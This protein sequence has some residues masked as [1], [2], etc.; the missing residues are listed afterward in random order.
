MSAEDYRREDQ[1]VVQAS[2]FFSQLTYI[3]RGSK[4]DT[5]KGKIS[6]SNELLRNR[7]EFYFEKKKEKKKKKRWKSFFFLFFLF[8]FLCEMEEFM[9]C[10]YIGKNHRVHQ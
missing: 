7:E 5:I 2:M 10:I 9:K 4:S 3:C 1:K 6:G 8:F